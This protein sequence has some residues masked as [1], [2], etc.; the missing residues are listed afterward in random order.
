M[1]TISGY[2]ERKSADGNKFYALILQGGMELVLSESS[3]RYYATAKQAS[4]TSTF[5]E[6]TCQGLVGTKLPGR[7]TKVVT[8]PFEYTV[9]ESGEIILLNHRWV[10]SPSEATLEETIYEKE[11]IGTVIEI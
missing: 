2:A 6:K 4:I 9:Q 1:V 3:G 5:D 8:E 10:Y 7:V 11:P